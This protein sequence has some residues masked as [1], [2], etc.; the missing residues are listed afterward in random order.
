MGNQSAQWSEASD[1]IP[2]FPTLVWKIELEAQLREAIGSRVLA[3]LTHLRRD[4]PPLAPGLGWQSVQSL[5]E[6]ADFRDLV[7]CA[8]R[9]VPGILRFLRIG[10][11][12]YEVTSLLG[13]SLGERRGTQDAPAPQ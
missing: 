2:M 4:L 6:L 5:H 1:V 9:I 13:D 8:H 12:A 10:Y 7:S 11:D 3:A